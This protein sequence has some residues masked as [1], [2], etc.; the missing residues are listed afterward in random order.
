[1]KQKT[2]VFTYSNINPPKTAIKNKRK[3]N[4]KHTVSSLT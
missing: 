2:N 1:M 3:D 4:T